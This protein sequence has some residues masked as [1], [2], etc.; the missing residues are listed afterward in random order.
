MLELSLRS[1]TLTEDG[2]YLVAVY[3]PEKSKKMGRSSKKHSIE[4]NKEMGSVYNIEICAKGKAPCKITKDKKVTKIDISESHF[5]VS[6]SRV[7]KLKIFLL[8]NCAKFVVRG[9]F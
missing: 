6:R 7:I 4:Q 2:Q 1:L 3:D 9:S 5:E 8:R